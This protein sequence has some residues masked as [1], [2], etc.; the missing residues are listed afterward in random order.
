MCAL[1]VTYCP[2]MT[3]TAHRLA[4]LI[5]ES[6]ESDRRLAALLES[7]RDL[8]ARTDAMLAEERPE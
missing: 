1:F 7:T 6:E 4:A 5:A 2:F 3:D 8:I